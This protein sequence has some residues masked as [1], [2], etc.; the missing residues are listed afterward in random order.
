MRRGDPERG[1]GRGELRTGHKTVNK[2][3]ITTDRG[4]RRLLRKRKRQKNWRKRLPGKSSNSRGIRHE[5]RRLLR[6]R[7]R[8]GKHKPEEH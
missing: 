1:Q 7:R 5:S 3:A 2:A 6:S 4:G 8:P